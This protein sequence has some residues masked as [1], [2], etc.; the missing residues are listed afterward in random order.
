[1]AVVAKIGCR[2][3]DE[4]HRIGFLDHH[5][6]VHV[7][8][9]TTHGLN[10][11]A[12]LESDTTHLHASEER[13]LVVIFQGCSGDG[14][15]RRRSVRTVHTGDETDTPWL[16]R[17]DSQHDHIVGMVGKTLTHKA[18]FP[19]LKFHTGHCRVQVQ[20]AAVIS[21]LRGEAGEKQPQVPAWLIRFLAQRD[22]HEFPRADV[23]SFLLA[24]PCKL[25]LALP[26]Q[27]ARFVEQVAH[28]R[29]RRS[30]TLVVIAVRTPCPHR[31]FVEL[32]MLAAIPPK[33][34]APNRPLPIG[35]ASFQ[36]FAGWR[37]QS[38]GDCPGLEELIRCCLSGKLAPPSNFFDSSQTACGILL[39]FSNVVYF[40]SKMS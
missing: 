26:L 1:M 25:D 15:R 38:F 8:D 28:A 2:S 31:A 3:Q 24:C 22:A 9:L 39:P 29:Q 17:A 10:R 18:G 13:K 16:I 27:T 12:R 32:K 7:A 21:G 4:H 30:G 37:Y 5:R 6:I 11:E 34:I 23:L 19:D 33:T 40:R 20:L 14:S 36:I 35:S